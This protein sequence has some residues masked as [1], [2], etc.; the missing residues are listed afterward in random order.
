MYAKRLAERKLGG[1][2]K[3]LPHVATPASMPSWLTQNRQMR[4]VL[5][6]CPEQSWTSDINL[7]NSAN[8][9]PGL[10]IVCSKG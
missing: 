3:T 1:T 8:V 9:M 5:G 7:L 10:A 4:V 2:L 6:S